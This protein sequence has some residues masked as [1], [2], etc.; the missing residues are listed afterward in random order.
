MG[1]ILGDIAGGWT[2]IKNLGFEIIN[3]KNKKILEKI[4]AEDFMDGTLKVKE[5]HIICRPD[6]FEYLKEIADLRK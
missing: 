1:F 3:Y 5:V 2:I 6:D 4:S